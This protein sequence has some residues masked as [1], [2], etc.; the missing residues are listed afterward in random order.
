MLV[1]ASLG[2][3]PAGTTLFQFAVE[4]L[5]AVSLRA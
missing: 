4:L 3:T 5:L 1:A 2:N